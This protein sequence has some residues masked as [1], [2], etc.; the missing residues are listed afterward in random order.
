MGMTGKWK[1]S[2]GRLDSRHGKNRKIKA[3]KD[4]KQPPDQEKMDSGASIIDE[5]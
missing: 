3:S 2:N 4:A 5:S 1:C